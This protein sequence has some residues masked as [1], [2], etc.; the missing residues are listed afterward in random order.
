MLSRESGHWTYAPSARQHLGSTAR[1]KGEEN[2][3]YGGLQPA[4]QWDKGRTK[5]QRVTSSEL[6]KVPSNPG[7]TGSLRSVFQDQVLPA[8]DPNLLG[9]WVKVLTD[10]RLGRQ[11][12]FARGKLSLK[13]FTNQFCL[14]LESRLIKESSFLSEPLIQPQLLP[15]LL[16]PW[17]MGPG[18]QLF[19]KV[20][21]Y[22]S[23]TA[24]DPEKTSIGPV[25]DKSLHS[26]KNSHS[27]VSFNFALLS[28]HHYR[29]GK[30]ETQD[31]VWEGPRVQVES[32]TRDPSWTGTYFWLG[33]FRAISL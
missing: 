25:R 15:S 8:S 12:G 22:L 17:D 29:G 32:L 7:S 33:G 13:K 31:R 6:M 21:V 11:T 5:E 4:H 26:L 2:L 23:K 27:V 9:L 24:S 30:R 1:P 16:H 3:I 20:L 10:I 14:E 28:S 18:Q 19:H